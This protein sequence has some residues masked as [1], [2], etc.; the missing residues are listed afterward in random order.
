MKTISPHFRTLFGSFALAA[1]SSDANTGDNSAAAVVDV[2]P[3]VVKDA[4]C[5]TSQRPFVFVHGTY[6]SGDNFAHVAALLGS[7][8]FCQDRIYAV[9]Y[10]SL[11]DKPGNDC[12]GATPAANCGKLDAA[13]DKILAETGADKVDLAGHSQGTAHCGAYLNGAGEVN[14]DGTSVNHPDAATAHQAKVAHYIN[15]SGRPDVGDVETLSLSSEHDLPG[16]PPPP[17]HATGNKVKAVTLTDE[18]HFAV[19]ASTRSFVELYK[20]LKGED[21]QYTEVQCGDKEV[22][23]EGIAETFADNT[24][25]LG[26]AEF[27][28]LGATPDSPGA[29]VS[30]PPPDPDG[31]FGPIKLKRNVPYE[32]KGFDANGKLIGYQ[33]FT[34]FKR[35][36]RLVRL[37]SPA[38]A[39]D[40]SAVGGAIASLST[41]HIVRD[42]GHVALVARWAG[43]AFRQDLGASLTIDGKEVFTSENAGEAA[44]SAAGLSGGVVGFFMSDMNTNKKTDLGLPYSAPFLAFTDVYMDATKSKFIELK[45]KAG[46]EDSKETG[47]VKIGSWSS[48]DGTV[49]AMF[50]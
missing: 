41:D 43:G 21:P 17:H 23:V 18:D 24:P 13:I 37:L 28:E 31:H 25:V 22:T 47:T 32:I 44:F 38:S 40:G 12:A 33:Y 3:V 45:F 42:K 35:S 29:K 1:C 39:D 6:G 30:V 4:D 19:A 16:P 50:Q 5:D 49:L 26:T 20:Y 14:Q 46:S 48:A 34:P 2:C 36:N 11:G 10:N 7:N 8:G 15:F 9:E 27:R